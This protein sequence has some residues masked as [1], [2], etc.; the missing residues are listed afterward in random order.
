MD[1]RATLC[2]RCKVGPESNAWKGGVT[3]AEAIRN[4][5]NFEK[6]YP[7]KLHA[8]RAANRAFRDGK[9]LRQPCE[10][11]NGIAEMHHDDYTQPLQVRWL[12]RTHHRQF[13]K[14]ATNAIC[15]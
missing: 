14:Q 3:S 15:K 13:H 9:I 1:F 6:K 5:R 4:K 7:E 10:I 2:Q 12:C 8:Q 11:C